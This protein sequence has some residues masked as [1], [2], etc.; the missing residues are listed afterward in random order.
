MQPDESVRFQRAARDLIAFASPQYRGGLCRNT[1]RPQK[2]TGA[3]TEND[4]FRL[5]KLLKDTPAGLQYEVV[6]I[7]TPDFKLSSS[8]V[9]SQFSL[10][11]E[12]LQ[13]PTAVPTTKY[14]PP[15]WVERWST[16]AN[17]TI[18]VKLGNSYSDLKYT[19][20]FISGGVPSTLDSEKVK[21]QRAFNPTLRQSMRNKVY[22]IH[23]RVGAANVNDFTFDVLILFE[24]NSPCWQFVWLPRDHD[25]DCLIQTGKDCEDEKE[26]A[27]NPSDALLQP[28]LTQ[29]KSVGHA[30]AWFKQQ[31]RE[32]LYGFVSA[33]PMGEKYEFETVNNKF[34]PEKEAKTFEQIETHLKR[35]EYVAF[36]LIDYN[37]FK[38]IQQCQ[39]LILKVLS[40]LE[41][42]SSITI[43]NGYSLQKPESNP[44]VTFSLPSNPRN[45][46]PLPAFIGTLLYDLWSQG[47]LSN[48]IDELETRLA[49]PKTDEDGREEGSEGGDDEDDGAA[50]AADEENDKK[51]M[52][53]AVFL[54]L[55]RLKRIVEG[56]PTGN[57]L[58][59]LLTAAILESDVKDRVNDIHEYIRHARAFADTYEV[60]AE[61]ISDFHENLAAD[62]EVDPSL[63]AWLH[64]RVP[65][66]SCRPSRCA[67][68]VWTCSRLRARWAAS[69]STKRRLRSM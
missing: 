20:T 39:A 44:F 45:K 41:K 66:Y 48:A 11:D 40:G 43:L 68:V 53:N 52:A 30:S 57:V 32:D 25:T 63:Q 18:T 42:G 31:H 67:M 62:V 3:T 9:F 37:V 56:A 34:K 50:T 4:L 12:A 8:S 17:R 55:Q 36:V 2:K 22:A 49:A 46:L 13:F 51:K 16:T 47:R 33:S 6:M 29:L 58:Q 54:Q 19:L 21:Q 1:D 10:N 23:A 5:E 28:F 27:P 59:D 69:W 60:I 14:E 26:P 7:S 24:A 15:K 65:S 61:S 38:E 64:R 35:V